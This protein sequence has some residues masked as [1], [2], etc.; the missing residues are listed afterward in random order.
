MAFNVIAI[1]DLPSSEVHM[2]MSRKADCIK[3][4]AGQQQGNS[5][6]MYGSHHI[7]FDY[8]DVAKLSTVFLYSI[9]LCMCLFIEAI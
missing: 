7:H 8:F 6:F 1:P 4:T 2:C 3:A 9:L 5:H